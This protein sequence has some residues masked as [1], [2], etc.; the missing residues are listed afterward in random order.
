MAGHVRRS[1][2]GLVLCAD[3]VTAGRCGCE[4]AFR[5][6]PWALLLMERWHARVVKKLARPRPASHLGGPQLSSRNHDRRPPHPNGFTGALNGRAACATTVNTATATAE[7]TSPP[8]DAAQA[9][10]TP[11]H[12]HPAHNPV[13]RE[14][15][16]AAHDEPAARLQERERH[17]ECA[18]VAPQLAEAVER[19]GGR[20]RKI[21]RF[22]SQVW[23]RM[24]HRCGEGRQ[25]I[26]AVIR[27]SANFACRTAR[28]A[29]I[30]WT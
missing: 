28:A 8:R 4:Q 5:S 18:A 21:G 16:H 13:R 7:D 3:R 11:L 15:L 24:G 25:C 10:K 14:L 6:D 9:P 17:T 1:R 26:C 2:M 27:G 29:T 30:S 20:G 12:L 19:G 22:P 23:Q